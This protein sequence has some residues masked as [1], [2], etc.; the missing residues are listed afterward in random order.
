MHRIILA[1]CFLFF[2]ACSVEQRQMWGHALQRAG[3]D[4]MYRSSTI[5]RTSRVAGSWVTNCY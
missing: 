4:M 2:T 1:L 5:C 3:D